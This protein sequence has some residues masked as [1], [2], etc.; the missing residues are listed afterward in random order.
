MHLKHRRS[1]FVGIDYEPGGI[2]HYLPFK[3]DSKLQFKI[4][5]DAESFCYL[6]I[7]QFSMIEIMRFFKPELDRSSH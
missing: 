7:N 5:L 2:R 1:G 6:E 4:N 3:Y